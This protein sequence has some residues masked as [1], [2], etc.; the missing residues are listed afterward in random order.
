MSTRAFI[1]GVS[2]TELT[3]AE[4]A[5]VRAESAPGAIPFRLSF[6]I[7]PQVAA[8][9][10]ELTGPTDP[11]GLSIPVDGAAERVHPSTTSAT[12]IAQVIRSAIGFQDLLTSNDGP[13][14][15][16]VGSIGER[17]RAKSRAGT[18]LHSNDNAELDALTANTA[19]A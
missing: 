6:E 19:S 3:A 17:S 1:T 9:L 10:W 14:K 18:P 7:S 15:A 12:M 13:M 5:F 4:R 16:L 11:A 2:G 8:S